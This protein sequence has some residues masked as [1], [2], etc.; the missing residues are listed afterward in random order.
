MHP[1]NIS[2]TNFK[3]YVKMFK[4]FNEKGSLH[5]KQQV[6]CYKFS[7]NMTAIASGGS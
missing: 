2:V 4:F 3:M 1:F 5:N 6:Y 7:K